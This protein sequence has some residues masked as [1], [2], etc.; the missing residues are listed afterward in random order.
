MKCK[1][2]EKRRLDV[3]DEATFYQYDID[4]LCDI[5]WWL[6]GAVENDS[7]ISLDGV[8][9]ESL[10]SLIREIRKSGMIVDEPR[11]MAF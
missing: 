9:I 2:C 11:P 5:I 4:S 10:S 8:H 6:K 7:S 1:E 3:K